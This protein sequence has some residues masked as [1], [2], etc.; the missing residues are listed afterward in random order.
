MF[1]K[2][3]RRIALVGPLGGR[4]VA[5]HTGGFPLAPDRMLPDADVVLLVG[6]PAQ[7][8]MLF[9]YTAHGEMCGDTPHSSVA[10][11]QHQA[12]IEYGEALFPWIDVP[13]DI[14][15]AHAFAIQYAANRLNERGE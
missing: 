7:G 2:A 9:R 15:D 6:D 5:V 1:Q 3:T 4:R 10:A 12:R 8:T 13:D 11:A 14:G